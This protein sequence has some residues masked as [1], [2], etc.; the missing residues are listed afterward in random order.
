LRLALGPEWRGGAF[1][2]ILEGGTIRVGD[3]V[4]W[5]A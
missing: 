2:E 1:G 4:R 5:L 3:A